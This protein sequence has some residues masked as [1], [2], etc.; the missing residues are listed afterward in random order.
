V[1]A[2]GAILLLFFIVRLLRRFAGR[3]SE[4]AITRSDTPANW[5]PEG[6][7]DLTPAQ[8]QELAAAGKEVLDSLEPYMLAAKPDGRPFPINVLTDQEIMAFLLTYCDRALEVIRGVDTDI[9]NE[10]AT[11]EGGLV[12]FHLW[13]AE[14][15]RMKRLFS[16]DASPKIVRLKGKGGTAK[17]F[18]G[19]LA[20]VSALQTFAMTAT[21][22]ETEP[23]YEE[24]AGLRLPV[25]PPPTRLH[26]RGPNAAHAQREVLSFFSK[27]LLELAAKA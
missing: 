20:A 12:M 21:S 4:Q 1:I 15:E 18:I 10:E 25:D 27:R 2:I 17:L 14:T 24:L 9:E 26:P 3:R 7:T 19:V 6:Y 22:E 8:K 23:T 11:P 16:G 5:I 13:F